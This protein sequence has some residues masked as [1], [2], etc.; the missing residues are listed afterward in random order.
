MS[1]FR[2]NTLYCLLAALS[3]LP[4]GL[5]AETAPSPVRPRLR[6]QVME[7]AIRDGEVHRLAFQ[8]S[9]GEYLGIVVEQ[10]GIDVM[11]ELFDPLDRKILEMDSPD[12]WWWEE[13]IALVAEISGTY[14]LEVRPFPSM[15]PGFYRARIDGP[16]APRGND[17]V[18]IEAVRERIAA[19]AH[20]QEDQE[21]LGHLEAALRLWSS[22]GERRRQAE[23]LHQMTETLKDLGRPV[24]AAGRFH[25]AVA[26]WRELDLPA[27][28]AWTLVESSRPGKGFFRGEDARKHLEDALALAA[29]AGSPFLEHRILCFGLGSFHEPRTALPYLER[30]LRV[31]RDAR[32]R[33]LEMR[34]LYQLGY[35][36]DDLSEKQEALRHYEE[37]LRICRE[38]QAEGADLDTF[39]ANV[40]NSLGH[41]YVSLG[42]LEK[43]AEHLQQALELSRKSEDARKEA[44][45]LNNLA[46][47]YVRLDPVKARDLYERSLTLVHGTGNRQGEVMTMNNLAFL[48]LRTGNPSRALERSRSA[49]SLAAGDE[50][51]ESHVRQAMGI[52]HRILGDLEA[53]RRELETALSLARKRQD[54]FRQ[55][56]VIP[57]LARTERMAR[58]LP[59]ALAL[60]EEGVLL[61][62]SLRTEMV[63]EEL[64]ATFLASRQETYR[65]HIDTLMAQGHDAE[66]LRASERARARTLLDTLAAAAA[67]IH[68]DA[69]PALLDRERL[70]LADIE[71][72]EKRHLMLLDRGTDAPELRETLTRLAAAIEEH[73]RV[74]A[75]L[76]KSSPRYA[77]LTQP[78]PLGLAEIQRD[79]LDG[80][81]LLLE[82]ALGEEK[83]YL[84]AVTADSLRSF[85]LP[86]RERIEGAARRWYGALVVPPTDPGYAKAAETA[87]KAADE[88]SLM[89]LGPVR[90]LLRDQPLLVVGDGA[91]HYLPFA[92]LPAP[93]SLGGSGGSG[94]VALIARHEVVSLP[95]A[96]ALAVLRRE[97]A[98][99]AAAPKTLAVL[100]DPVFQPNDPRAARPTLQPAKLAKGSPVRGG[101]I[102]DMGDPRA[103]EVDPRRL[104]RLRF[105]GRE[106]EAIAALVPE[107]Q[108]FKALGFAA[109][110]SV[111]TGGELARYRMVH[112][113]THGLID[114]LRPE[115]SSLVLS[116]VNEKGEP[117]N[118]FLRLHDIYNLELNADLVVLSAC[119]TALGQEIR[120]EGLVGLTRGFMYAGAARVLAS[121]WS[122]DDR[123][124]SLLMR[125][126]YEH[127]ITGGLRPAAALRQ[128]QIDMSRDSQW[129]SPYYW[130]GFSL[131]GEWR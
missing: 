67:D 7:S 100:A 58:N 123:A 82:Y 91:L 73:V 12:F 43:A 31:A 72:L 80:R 37:A 109:S 33:D 119:Q 86:S 27:Q 24:E 49:L 48:D 107:T 70:L 36:L 29:R 113:A 99:R 45:A 51:P 14:R 131:Q 68:K 124:T 55:S 9:A 89:L 6:A 11:L 52:A 65:L 44:A 126:F 5:P 120:G 56:Q 92:A 53:S 2:R 97:I 90:E 74:Q 17:A 66:A 127:M 59:R 94:R 78:Q 84:W 111:A 121:L 21:R 30:S 83:S 116:L 117:Q 79:V 108:R 18:R 41:L 34:S 122:V 19:H 40:L 46:L 26:I 118:G 1:F 22:L 98:G 23:T 35:T 15:A 81:A 87:R 20:A 64:R 16:R 4:A 69:D 95:S 77:A 115:M 39:L 10:G 102:G 62:E 76:R 13:E 103:R 104:S 63:Q 105:S 71:A 50:E 130:A 112:F 25:Q 42:H 88:L 54:R 28:Q 129:Q 75:E 32:D 96:S 38:L 8:L 110:R 85:E 101:D 114:S 93:D 47:V 60:L 106:A 128:A 3:L 57:E 61:L 125:R